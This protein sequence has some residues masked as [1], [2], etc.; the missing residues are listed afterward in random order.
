MHLYKKE[1]DSSQPFA[2]KQCL[3]SQLLDLEINLL[4]T[5]LVIALKHGHYQNS[6]PTLDLPPKGRA[7]VVS[8]GHYL[9]T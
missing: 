7:T 6:A 1:I 3:K 8:L 2:F 5:M 9:L 4:H